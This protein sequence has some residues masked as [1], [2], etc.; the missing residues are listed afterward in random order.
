LKRL[1]KYKFRIIK[2]LFASRIVGFEKKAVSKSIGNGFK[3]DD[4]VLFLQ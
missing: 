1:F 2:H 4:K 3:F